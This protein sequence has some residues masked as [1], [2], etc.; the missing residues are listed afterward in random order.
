MRTPKAC[1]RSIFPNPENGLDTQ[2]K[3]IVLQSIWFHASVGDDFMYP[4]VTQLLRADEYEEL[5][6]T[7]VV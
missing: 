1:L 6:L 2:M 7:S 3:P 5:D 4:D